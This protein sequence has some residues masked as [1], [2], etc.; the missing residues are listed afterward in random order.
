MFNNPFF[1]YQSMIPNMMRGY[2]KYDDDLCLYYEKEKVYYDNKY[3]ECFK[4]ALKD[5]EC[6]K[7]NI[8]MVNGETLTD[9]TLDEVERDYI[10]CRENEC[11]TIYLL[12]INKICSVGVCEDLAKDLWGHK[13]NKKDPVQAPVQP[14][15]N[16]NPCNLCR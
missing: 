12:P 9:V 10:A 2:T 4:E 8:T 16:P 7:V 13:I 6:K 14:A 5:L 1:Y 3:P 15:Y 11:G